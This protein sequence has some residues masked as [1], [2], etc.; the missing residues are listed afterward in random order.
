MQTSS[1]LSMVAAAIAFFA[2]PAATQ[3]PYGYLVVSESATPPDYSVRYVE[4]AT[5]V[6]TELRAGASSVNMLVGGLSVD[7]TDPTRLYSAPL[8]STSIAAFLFWFDL[9]GSRYNGLRRA[10]IPGA[11]GAPRR[12]WAL[13]PGAVLAT[14]PSPTSGGLWSVDTALSTATQLVQLNDATDIAVLGNLAYVNSYRA[15][16]PSTVVEVDL[17]TSQTR[18]VGSNLPVIRSLGTFAG[19]QL[20]GGTDSGDLLQIDPAT[21]NT[22]LMLAPGA[23]AVIAMAADPVSGLPYFA[24]DQN[25]IRFFANPT[26]VYTTT[27]AIQDI[28]AGV[29]AL[30]SHLQFGDGCVGSNG[31]LPTFAYINVPALGS[32]Y[33]IEASG[34]I[35][36][37]AA[38]LVAG[39]SRTT[40][41]TG[42]PLPLPLASLLPGAGATCQAY[43]DV[44]GTLFQF[45]GVNGAAQQVLALPNDPLL[46]G[47]HVVW[48][49]LLFD[50]MAPGGAV[51]SDGAESILM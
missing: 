18:V 45:V 13:G 48:Q 9:Q 42:A 16:Q 25:E 12:F 30:P 1:R 22:T 27:N 41:N 2:L 14:V 35:P 6:V 34:G 23:G 7:P 32:S 47:Q 29:H 17:S 50:A 28:D 49:W 36:G 24:T 38:F 44:F 10:A 8:L 20:V 19:S 26:P 46:S 43:T 15:G 5:G 21:G 11:A 37:A 51:V 4:P 3:V 39:F 40:F 31:Q 33:T